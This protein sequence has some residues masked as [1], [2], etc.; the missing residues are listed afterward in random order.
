MFFKRDWYVV[1]TR[2]CLNKN[3]CK[4]AFDDI[5]TSNFN[6]A[7]AKE[8]GMD[9]SGHLI[10]HKEGQIAIIQNVF[11]NIDAALLYFDKSK[12][13]YKNA[14]FFYKIYIWQ[15]SARFK[16]TAKIYLP[17]DYNKQNG[18]ILKT[19]PEWGYYDPYKS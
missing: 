9:I 7:V 11:S 6:L 15:I 14:D 3:H 17:D 19:Y 1:E 2:T 12:S 10:S 5:G 18:T 8:H 13:I 4:I 16:F